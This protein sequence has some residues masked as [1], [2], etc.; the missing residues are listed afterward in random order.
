MN[1]LNDLEVSD[2]KIKDLAV[3]QSRIIKGFN[4]IVKF[5]PNEH[6]KCS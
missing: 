6:L 3:G 1:L 4:D 2:N 5:I